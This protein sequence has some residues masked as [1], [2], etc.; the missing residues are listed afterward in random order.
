MKKSIFYIIALSILLS[1]CSS[2]GQEL[3]NNFNNLRIAY[4]NDFNSHMSNGERAELI[5]EN[6]MVINGIDDASVVVTGH[7]ALIG[8]DISFDN[9]EEIDRIKK[10]AAKCAR[11]S[12]RG[13]TNTAVTNNSE[14]LDM[15]RDM[16][17]ERQ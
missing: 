12:D 13:I 15:I 17:E 10:E 2:Q 1:G 3:E 14:I 9:R 4:G 7:T 5:K 8:L 16:E 11:S 6:I